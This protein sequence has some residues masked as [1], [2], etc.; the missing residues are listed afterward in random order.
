MFEEIRD[1]AD[2]DFERLPEEVQEIIKFHEETTD[3]DREFIYLRHN[4]SDDER[5]ERYDVLYGWQILNHAS[6]CDQFYYASA[7]RIDIGEEHD[8]FKTHWYTLSR[9][10][11]ERAANFESKHKEEGV[12]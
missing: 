3:E 12:A 7:V 1:R 6:P 5:Y 8:D 11:I 4:L 9:E 10:E 2:V